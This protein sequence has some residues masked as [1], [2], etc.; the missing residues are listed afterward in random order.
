MAKRKTRFDHITIDRKWRRSLH[1]VRVK[2][3]AHAAI[4]H[5]LVN[6]EIQIKLKAY[7]D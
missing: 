2:C 1:G 4:D 6:S 7:K 3:G 5:Y